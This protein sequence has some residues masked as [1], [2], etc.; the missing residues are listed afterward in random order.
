MDLRNKSK[1]ELEDVPEDVAPKKKNEPIVSL[2]KL[3]RDATLLYVPKKTGTKNLSYVHEE[4]SYGAIK[5][6]VNFLVHVGIDN[7]NVS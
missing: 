3:Y 7:I 6:M 5:K 4:M 2:E 1:M